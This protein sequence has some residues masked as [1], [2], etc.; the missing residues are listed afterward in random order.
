MTTVPA[1]V[2][3]QEVTLAVTA[4]GIDA[5]GEHIAWPDVDLWGEDG[6]A[7]VLGVA[8][9]IDGVPVRREISH[10]GSQ[11]D[12]LAGQMRELRGAARRACLAQSDLPVVESFVA[13]AAGGI[14]DV[15]VL[16]QG[17]VVEPRGHRATFT[18]WG[19]VADVGREGYRLTLRTRWG[20]PVEVSGLGERTDEFLATVERVRGDLARATR[21][22]AERRGATASPW[23]DGW[24][25][26]DGEAVG[27]WLDA[28]DPDERAVLG[29]RL[30]DIRAG[31]FTEGG[32]I[33]LAFILGR[34]G[35]DTVVVEGVGVDDRAT[36]AFTADDIDRVNA[37]L[38]AS[39]FRRELLY[40][41]EERLGAACAA[42]RTQDEIRWL[43]SALR[44]RIPH[45][46]SWAET[47]GALAES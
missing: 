28:I 46:A 12:S 4:Q 29:E 37:A 15:V 41:P 11:R 22:A 38:L 26:P 19:L 21:M 31:M 45:D 6:H 7:I 35:R 43:R 36:Y 17:M 13:R 34:L 2:D 14:T 5:G 8:H 39:S 10:L 18:P 20:A 16:P 33:E 30:T 24:A 1:R 27:A 23:A 47:L 25:I 44:A 40:W 9:G 3:G 42:L 32:R